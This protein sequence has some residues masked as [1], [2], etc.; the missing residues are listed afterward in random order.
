MDE[1]SRRHRSKHNRSIPIRKSS[2]TRSIASVPR[3]LASRRVRQRQTARPRLRCALHADGY[4]LTNS[5]VVNGAS[6]LAA[7][8]TDGREFRAHSSA[9]IRKPISPCYGCRAAISVRDTRQLLGAARRPTRHRDRQSVRLSGNGNRRN[10]QRART[11]LANPFGPPDR[12]R[13]SDGCTAQ[14]RQLRRAARRRS[15][16]RRRHQHRDR[17]RAQGICFA[18]G[19]DI[20]TNVATR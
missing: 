14:S 17:G 4:L 3:S 15:R 20:A 18:I 5:H 12:K 11:K 8:L 7:T 2:R 10:R 6:E 19:I 9:T 1:C 13:D 16:P